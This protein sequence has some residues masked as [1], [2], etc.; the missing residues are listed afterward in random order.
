MLLSLS[1]VFV[2]FSMFNTVIF[3]SMGVSI[4]RSL[5]DRKME[6]WE[7]GRGFSFMIFPVAV[8]IAPVAAISTG[9]QPLSA[10]PELVTSFP[11]IAPSDLQVLATLS[12]YVLVPPNPEVLAA[13]YSYCI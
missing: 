10:S 2:V 3:A 6:G 4:G 8:G 1:L 13:S 9:C 12:F 7:E 5:Y 11:A